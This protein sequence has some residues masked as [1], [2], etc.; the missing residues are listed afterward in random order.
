SA[1]KKE[2]KLFVDRLQRSVSAY[3]DS[4]ASGA[5]AIPGYTKVPMKSMVSRFTKKEGRVRGQ[6]NAKR[7]DF[8][9]RSV[10]TP[11]VDLDIDQ[12]GVP[13]YVCMRLTYP[14]IDRRRNN[15]ACAEIHSLG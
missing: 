10:I 6:L 4:D 1:L 11:S 15:T 9:A 3:I 12:L 2:I 13:E 8:C 7:V 5:S 14:E